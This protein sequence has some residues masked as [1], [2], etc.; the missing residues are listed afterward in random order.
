MVYI[1]TYQYIFNYF[2]Q[3]Y[4][5]LLTMV[6][7]KYCSSTHTCRILVL[8]LDCDEESS[9]NTY[10]V[11]RICVYSGGAPSAPPPAPALGRGERPCSTVTAA[12]S[13]SVRAA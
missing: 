3:Q 10:L 9:E 4:L 1:K 11:R 2:Y 5:V 13:A 6:P 12:V 7:L 8:I